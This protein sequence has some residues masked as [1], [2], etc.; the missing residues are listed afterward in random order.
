[1]KIE[2]TALWAALLRLAAYGAPGTLDEL[3]AIRGAGDAIGK[4]V[5]TWEAAGIQILDEGGFTRTGKGDVL[6][7][8]TL[9]L[10]SADLGMLLNGLKQTR[11]NP[12]TTPGQMI[13]ELQKLAEA[14][15]SWLHEAQAAEQWEQLPE[16]QRQIIIAKER[17]AR[18]ASNG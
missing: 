15:H 2:T 8:V 18:G 11:W 17:E 4:Q 10:S 3:A 1:M 5:T 13:A 14:L 16:Q 12:Q 7:P 6:A 9:D